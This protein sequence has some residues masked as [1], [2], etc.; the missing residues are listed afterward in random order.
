[1][2][3]DLFMRVH[4]YTICIYVC[5]AVCMLWSIRDNSV[6]CDK[7]IA[8]TTASA[9]ADAGATA[10]IVGV[11]L[12]E[13]FTWTFFIFLHPIRRCSLTCFEILLCIFLSTFVYSFVRSFY[14][15]LDIFFNNNQLILLTHSFTL[16]L[17][18]IFSFSFFSV[19]IYPSIKLISSCW[20]WAFSSSPPNTARVLQ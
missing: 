8:V 5:V 10:V 14:A 3:F 18:F 11:V 20:T 12:C 9:A 13:R 4:E 7:W 2:G 16:V 1:M 6:Y 15:L 19:C 17:S